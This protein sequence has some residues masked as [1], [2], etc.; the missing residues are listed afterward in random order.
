MSKSNPSLSQTDVAR[1]N[2]SG[3][4]TPE[5]ARPQAW[6][7]AENLFSS[8]RFAGMGIWYACRTQR[9]FRIHVA[10]SVAVLSTSVLLHLSSVELALVSL[11]CG[12]VMVLEL[13]NTALEALVDLTVGN[14]Y[15]DLAKV[16]K[17]CAAASV[18]VSAMVSVLVAAFLLLPPIALQLGWIQ[19]L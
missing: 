2:S 10:V 16:A 13:L 7:V 15:H 5:W 1:S 8:F 18:L 9:N 19:A 3:D 17:D 14:H 4:V 12:M 11:T 6:L